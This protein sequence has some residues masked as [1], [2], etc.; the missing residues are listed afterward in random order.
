MEKSPEDYKEIILYIKAMDNAVR[1]A[2]EDRTE[3][4]FADIDWEIFTDAGFEIRCK[5][6]GIKFR[7]HTRCL[8]GCDKKADEAAKKK[9]AARWNKRH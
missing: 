9:L 7:E 3:H 4:I 1:N 6:C 8:P 5:H 2:T